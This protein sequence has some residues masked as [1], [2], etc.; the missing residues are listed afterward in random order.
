MFFH[1]MSLGKIYIKSTNSGALNLSFSVFDDFPVNFS[2]KCI[3]TVS[4]TFLLMLQKTQVH[5]MTCAI[6]ISFQYFKFLLKVE[7]KLK[8]QIA[9]WITTHKAPLFLFMAG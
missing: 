8:R 1:Y 9:T 3:T 5:N 4:R 2:L 6:F 7:G